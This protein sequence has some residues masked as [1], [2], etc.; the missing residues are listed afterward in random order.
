[1]PLEVPPPPADLLDLPA[2]PIVGTR[3]HRIYRRR[4]GQPWWFASIP[5]GATGADRQAAGRFD[6]AAP[7]GTCYLATTPLAAVLEGFQGYGRGLL[8]DVELR[9]RLRAEMTVPAG[10]RPAAWLTRSQARGRGVTQAL[11]A[12]DDR[13]LTQRWATAL[14]RAGWVALFHG[15]QHDPSGR[16]RGVSLFDTAGAHPPLDDAVGWAHTDHDLHTDAAITAGLARYGITVTRSD[17]DL[18]VVPLDESG[19]V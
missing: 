7:D 12:S 3:L 11:W 5:A 19:L 1:M 13:P 9:Q 18:P 17:P 8:P 10:F 4:R 2:R 6:L 16:L 15:I 14:R